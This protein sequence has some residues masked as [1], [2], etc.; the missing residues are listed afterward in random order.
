[1]KQV[2]PSP[3]DRYYIIAGC[4]REY[5]KATDFVMELQKKG[6][7]AELR[8]KTNGLHRVIYSAHPNYSSALGE[9]KQII[10]KEGRGPW[11]QKV[12]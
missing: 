8:G 10:D 3:N 2:E 5:N 9:M 4:F 11:I 1:M 7:T 12:K 6:Y